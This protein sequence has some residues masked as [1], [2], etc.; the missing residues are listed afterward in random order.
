MPSGPHWTKDETQHSPC[1]L[2][3]LF[4][5][6]EAHPDWWRGWKGGKPKKG[7]HSTKNEIARKIIAELRRLKGPVEKSVSAIN[8]QVCPA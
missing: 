5:I 7:G 6:L 4:I 1:S 3:L 8:T 2:E